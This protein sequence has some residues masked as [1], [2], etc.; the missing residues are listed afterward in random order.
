LAIKTLTTPKRP[1]S[2]K[3]Q[4]P[5]KTLVLPLLLIVIA[6]GCKPYTQKAPTLRASEAL[7]KASERFRFRSRFWSGG[8]LLARVG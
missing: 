8:W 6:E 1:R 4:Q 5:P 7:L 2:T 3:T